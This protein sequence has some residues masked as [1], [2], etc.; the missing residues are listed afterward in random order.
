MNYNKFYNDNGYV[1]YKDLISHDTCDMVKTVMDSWATKE[2]PSVMNPDRLE[3][4]VPQCYDNSE[5]YLTDN[6][7]KFERIQDTAKL[8]R[9]LMFDNNMFDKLQQTVGS[10]LVALCSH[11]FYKKPN[12]EYASQ[13]WAPHQ[14]NAWTQNENNRL[15]IAHIMIDKT[16]IENGCLYLYKGSH[17]EPLLPMLDSKSLT[18]KEARGK[19]VK[20]PQAYQSQRIDCVLEKGDVVV[21]HGNTIHG[22]YPNKSSY[23]RPT[24][25]IHY[26]PKG[27]DFLAGA[28]ARRKVIENN[29]QIIK[30]T[31][32]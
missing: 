31:G 13:S 30:G 8:M 25:S 12:T 3:Y 26:M 24:Y 29:P 5:E 20:I 19:S 11:Y 4:L 32:E 16:R 28:H 22:S 14:D 18:A 2:A 23:S 15:L 6:V 9:G 27:E 7:D 21:C 1:V 17:K 10:E